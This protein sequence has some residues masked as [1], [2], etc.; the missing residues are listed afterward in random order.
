MKRTA[1]IL[2]L[3]V[4]VALSTAA[5]DV[6]PYRQAPDSTVTVTPEGDTLISY[7]F[8]KV[9]FGRFIPSDG[10]RVPLHP[11]A[12]R[13]T[14][15]PK[16]QIASFSVDT[17]RSVGAIP[18]DESV[19]PTGGRIYN[20]PV[21]TSAWSSFS[22]Q[23]GITYNS[24]SGEG[25]AGYGWSISGLSAISV[26]AKNQYYHGESQVADLSDSTS[27]YA[28]D[29]DPLVHNDIL[30]AGTGYQYITARG[31]V[32]VKKILLPGGT[33]KYFEAL[34]P[35]GSAAVY[36]FPAD[37]IPHSTYPVSER[38]DAL[39]NI[40][41]FSYLWDSTD[42]VYDIEHI[43]YCGRTGEALK[44]E[45]NFTYSATG[46]YHPVQYYAG[47]RNRRTRL[48]KKVVSRQDGLELRTYSFSHDSTDI[49]L[50]RQIDCSV[51]TDSLNPLRFYYI[52]D[53]PEE[54]GIPDFTDYQD[55]G[56]LSRW[57]EGTDCF[58]KRGRFIG[59]LWHDGLIIFPNMPKYTVVGKKLEW[60]KWRY[61][62]GSG[63][64]SNQEIIIIP[65][66]EHTGWANI[67]YTGSGFQTIESADTD[68]NGID[69]SV[70][71]NFN[72]ISGSNTILKIT[73]YSFNQSTGALDSLVANIPVYGRVVEGSLES[74]IQREYFIG[75]WRGI[76]HDDLLTI[77][78]DVDASGDSRPCKAALID[79][80]TLQKI[81]ELDFNTFDLAG[82]PYA[83]G[84]D[85][86]GDGMSELMIPGTGNSSRMRQ[87][88]YDPDVQGMAL[89]TSDNGGPL[90]SSFSEY[91]TGIGNINGDRYQDFLTISG[92]PNY[93]HAVTCRTSAGKRFQ[94]DYSSNTIDSF[95]IDNRHFFI[96]LDK[97]G[98]TDV[99]TVNGTTIKF[100]LNRNGHF[101][102]PPTTS[103]Y[104]LPPSA[105]IIP[106]STR[107]LHGNNDFMAI[108]ENGHILLY[109]FG[110]DRAREKLLTN[111][112][113]GNGV[114]GTNNYGNVSELDG[115]LPDNSRSYNASEGYKKTIFPL[116]LLKE[117]SLKFS[118]ELNSFSI[119]KYNY[120]DAVVHGR[121]LGFCG[122][123]KIV[124]QDSLTRVRTTEIKNPEM[125]GVPTN[126]TVSFSGSPGTII[127]TTN[128]IWQKNETQY[129]KM[130]PRLVG[131]T[132][133]D[134]FTGNETYVDYYYDN[135]DFLTFVSTTYEEW[136][137]S[138][139]M[140]DRE[141][142]Y[143]HHLSDTLYRLGDVSIATDTRR[144]CYWWA[145]FSTQVQT[146]YNRFGQPVKV[147]N[148]AWDDLAPAS[149]LISTDSLSYD[150]RGRLIY[151]GSAPRGST[152]FIGTEYGYLGTESVPIES[153]D[154]FGRQTEFPYRDKYGNNLRAWND[155]EGWRTDFSYDAWGRQTG[156]RYH[157]GTRDTTATRW[158]NI[159][160]YKVWT[161]KAGQPETVVHYDAAG[162]EL[163]RSDK[164]FDGSWRHVD[165]EYDSKGQVARVSLP[166]KGNAPT[167]WTRYHYD[168]YGRV[169]TVYAA[170]GRKDVTV[171][172]GK[173]ITTT[174]NGVTRTRHMNARGE[175]TVSSD[176][177]GDVVNVYRPDGQMWSSTA[178]GNAM[179]TFWYDGT[180]RRTRMDSPGAGVHTYAY[181]INSA[182][183]AQTTVH[184]SPE[185]TVTSTSDK[186]GRLVGRQNGTDFS[187]V[188]NYS[189]RLLMSEVSTNGT[190]KD[191]TYDDHE[192]LA[193]V[194]ETGFDGKWLKQVFAYNNDDDG[195]IASTLLICDTDTLGTERYYYENGYK[196]VTSFLPYNAIS[197][198]D[199]IIVWKLTSENDLGLP[200]EGRS[201]GNVQ[202]T[203][204]YD[205]FGRPTRRTLG[206]VM[207]FGY[208]YDINDNLSSRS[209]NLRN[210]SESFTYDNL[211]R[212]TGAGLDNRTRTY[213]PNGNVLSDTKV[214]SY[215]YGD[216]SNPYRQTGLNRSGE[217]LPTWKYDVAFTSFSRPAS[218]HWDQEEFY[219]TD[220]AEFNYDGSYQKSK[221]GVGF[222][223]GSGD[224][225]F[226]EYFRY[227]FADRFESEYAN[228]LYWS[229]ILYLGGDAYSAPVALKRGWIEGEE[230]P[231]DA[232]WSVYNIG[233]DN[234]GSIT[235][236]VSPSGTK[237]EEVSYDPWGRPR[238]PSSWELYDYVT[239]VFS[240][241][242]GYGGH[243]FLY[244]LGIYHANARLYDPLTGRF[245]G[246]DPY[247]QDPDNTQN[248]NRYSYCLN[249]PF[250]YLDPS[251]SFLTWSIGRTGFSIGFNFT[252]VGIP[253]GLG[254][255]IGWAEGFSLGAYGEVGYRV[256]GTGFGS[257]ATLS[258]SFD[259]SFKNSSW[260]ET[261]GLS[262]YASLG[263]LNASLSISY[264]HNLTS[265][266]GSFNWGI[267]VGINL[268]GNDAFG[269]GL[270]VGYGSGGWSYG[271]GGYYNPY[272]WNDN[273]VFEPEEWND[274]GNL[275]IDDDVIV[276]YDNT[277]QLTNNCYSYALDDIDNGNFWGLQP[278]YAE[279]KPIQA[280]DIS[281]DNVVQAAIADGRIKVPTFLNKLGFGKK[282]YYSVYLVVDNQKDYH[283]YRQD[284]GGSWSHKRGIAPVANA[285][286]WIGTPFANYGNYKS[287]GIMLW[288]KR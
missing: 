129:R 94:I 98:L 154:S 255:N 152:Q 52:K 69:E 115:Y 211:D 203:Y 212:L 280:A 258:Q 200:T 192:R 281:L 287:G 173:N 23:I 17:T 242:R 111:T 162:R 163:R 179:T 271:L 172:D 214:G 188:W 156:I 20:I 186:F 72:G 47:E 86:D 80:S 195:N 45:I 56:Y 31:K 157:D 221:V 120:H 66:L 148:Y 146:S 79:L 142:Q 249:N 76:G 288:A 136:T 254:I 159:G 119:Q 270:N 239:S 149:E 260:S 50:L 39:G 215:V 248:W 5:Q 196:T 67:I 55:Y 105:Q 269:L 234:L 218:V 71:I 276:G 205:A 232:S 8:S 133:M 15:V 131:T 216:T 57:F 184:T 38:R 92:I 264:T 164:R 236:V 104:S 48:L 235:H 241:S 110:T 201:A 262:A 10:K 207:D 250:R 61:K 135:L 168:A 64:A 190:R 197:P 183:G 25:A 274:G 18:M 12:K 112:D 191:Y 140:E 253:L 42:N 46:S 88:S 150:S 24:Q 2:V 4:I 33:P 132:N 273:P 158:S 155:A 30:P 182:T 204:A 75:D 222:S 14:T 27:V 102:Y 63:Y 3:S 153:F 165:T 139:W 26:T 16:R 128:N 116:P 210:L 1:S 103:Y 93:T 7:I 35:D 161:K 147:R 231:E 178:P 237:I 206:S 259:Y 244:D 68:G 117:C 122:F 130:N 263:P 21:V 256:G 198:N 209:D 171:Y 32:A 279:G 261:T 199:T 43:R 230:S 143:A 194:K 91:T 177:A 181:S 19:S 90:V 213:A 77:N 34:F 160:L 49:T 227:Y 277:K 113:N 124:I 44:A 169:D 180:G 176:A 226:Y 40:I 96:D 123:G 114:A 170:N 275:Y 284:K 87:Y 84:A 174:A 141:I 286:R 101:S 28:L 225:I 167:Q 73:K 228:D 126:I 266:E 144:E 267:N 252:P 238:S 220:F 134:G 137:D 89:E 29:G 189:D 58:Y 62:Y 175:V 70:K 151:K 208:T 285:G 22:P 224:V 11:E 85:M 108:T 240:L 245:L 265:R 36:G 106:G 81:S 100:N 251:G 107:L 243:S 99:L 283:W 193:S 65:A 95:S 60:F 53:N 74:P 13:N 82:G 78:Y 217:D 83:I 127:G 185:G 257:G 145:E 219:T 6:Q 278:G 97:D 138:L 54:E 51:E 118:G 187:T 121:G 41:R 229:D 37:T 246:Y 247:V 282:G 59:N 109:T 166:Y 202:R 125:M 268:L 223:D 9:D 272:A 233:R